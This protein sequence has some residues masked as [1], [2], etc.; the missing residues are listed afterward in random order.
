MA[1][2]IAQV[3]RD[4]G[5]EGVVAEI[6]PVMGIEAPKG[7]GDRGARADDGAIDV[8]REPRQ[9]QARQGV[10]HDLLIEPDEGPERRVREPA[11]PVGDRAR[12]RDAGQPAEPADQRVA[13]EIFHMLHPSGPDV[14]Q[15]EQEQTQAPST[16]VSAKV[17]AR[18][19]QSWMQ[20]EAAHITAEQLE[21]PV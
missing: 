5:H 14:E 6:L 2:T 19:A 17:G 18:A 16:V 3:L 8:E 12:R 7:P 11:E 15:R 10:E 20:V 4:V 1:G 13:D 9:R 21:P